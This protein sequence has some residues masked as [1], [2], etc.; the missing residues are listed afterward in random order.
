[1]QQQAV[2]FQ[3]VFGK[4]GVVFAVAIADNG[5]NIVGG[6]GGVV[7]DDAHGVSFLLG[8]GFQAA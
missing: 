7:G 5:I 6:I 8:L 2:F 1:M 3:A 4:F